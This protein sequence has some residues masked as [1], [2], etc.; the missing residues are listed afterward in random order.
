M[1]PSEA[2]SDD[3][4]MDLSDL[5][6]KHAEEESRLQA[7][8]EQIKQSYVEKFGEPSPSMELAD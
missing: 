3:T 5:E 6:R 7:E 2:S 4:I 8:I 1:E